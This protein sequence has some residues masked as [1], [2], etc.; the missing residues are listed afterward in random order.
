MRGRVHQL[1]PH[2]S[3]APALT[4]QAR[5]LMENRAQLLE[6][7]ERNCSAAFYRLN[8]PG[9]PGTASS[10]I[11]ANDVG[12]YHLH[13]TSFRAPVQIKRQ[14]LSDE[15]PIRYSAKLGVSGRAIRGQAIRL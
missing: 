11:D 4:R 8:G 3:F 2:R 12:L 14:G 1:R 9:Q 13:A 10:A 7:A 6:A 15:L 5:R